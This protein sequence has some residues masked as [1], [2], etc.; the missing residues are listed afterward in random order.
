MDKKFYTLLITPGAHGR[1]R[2]FQLPFYVVPVVLALSIVGVVMLAG[3]AT[4][5]ARMLIKVSNYNT[6]RSEREALKQQFHTLE[7]KVSRTNV[8]LNSLQTLAAEV[9]VTYGFGNGH[10]QRIT[11]DLLNLA[12]QSSVDSGVNGEDPSL[13][14][15]NAMKN[16]S[17]NSVSGKFGPNSFP[18]MIDDPSAIPSIWPVHGRLTA[19]FGQRMDPFSGEEAFHP[20]VD[21]ADGMGTDVVAAGDGLV[22]EAEPD[23]GYGRSIMIDHG[24]GITTRYAHLGRIFVVVGEQVKQGEII[25]AIGMS[26]RTTGPHVHYEVR[27]HGTPVNPA[28]FLHG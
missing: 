17:L 4:S 1:V 3:L 26:G 20:G 28:R 27:I 16:V 14:A 11:P 7:N 13:Y 12:R 10:H 22:I 24:D 21:I 2:K 6:V 8:K 9:A 19:G 18:G 23:A 25:G 15:L 5:Y